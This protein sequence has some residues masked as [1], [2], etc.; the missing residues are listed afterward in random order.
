M[1]K[2][3]T[4]LF[5]SLQ[6]LLFMLCDHV[7]DSSLWHK[8]SCLVIHTESWGRKQKIIKSHW[9]QEERGCYEVTYELL[10]VCVH[11]CI[12]FSPSQNAVSLA[13]LK[14]NFILYNILILFWNV[15]EHRHQLLSLALSYFYRKEIWQIIQE[16]YNS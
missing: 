11:I 15:E 3:L 14:Q 12:E 5:L 10:C 8:V 9:R 7:I 13:P 6:D 4:G 1:S 2:H 16:T